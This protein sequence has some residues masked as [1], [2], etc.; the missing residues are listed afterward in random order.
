MCSGKADVEA[1]T[2]LT[3]SQKADP[4]WA[5]VAFAVALYAT[6]SSCML[7]VNKVIRHSIIKAMYIHFLISKGWLT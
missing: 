7:V 4:A 1:A 6:C 5:T 3:S 2:P